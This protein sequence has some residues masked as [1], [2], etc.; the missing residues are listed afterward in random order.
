MSTLTAPFTAKTIRKPVSAR[1][2]PEQLYYFFSPLITVLLLNL[3]NPSVYRFQTAEEFVMLILKIA[4]SAY[5]VFSVQ[6]LAASL[7][8]R[9]IVGVYAVNIT[10]LVLS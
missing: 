4:L 8:K 9:R 7:F 5:I 6:W 2:T 10:L 1:H 3:I